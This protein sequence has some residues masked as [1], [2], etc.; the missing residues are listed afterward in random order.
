MPVERGGAQT[1]PAHANAV[2]GRLT[3]AGQRDRGIVLIED[4]RQDP[5]W[6]GTPRCATLTPMVHGAD[7]TIETKGFTAECLALVSDLCYP[8]ASMTEVEAGG[9]RAANGLG[10]HAGPRPPARCADPRR[11]TPPRVRVP[12]RGSILSLLR[13]VEACLPV[14]RRRGQ[15]RQGGL[16]RRPALRRTPDRRARPRPFLPGQPVG[17]SGPPNRNRAHLLL[18]ARPV[19]GRQAD[20]GGAVRKGGTAAASCAPPPG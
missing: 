17:E 20:R 12:G 7:I 19:A 11:A 5:G 18:P 8:D 16:P 4:Q 3:V 14:C 2:G 1:A 13:A 6:C 10:F 15:A 9:R